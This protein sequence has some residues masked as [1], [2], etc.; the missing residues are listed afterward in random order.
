MRLPGSRARLFS[1]ARQRHTMLGDAKPSRSDRG[2]ADRSAWEQGV[3]IWFWVDLVSE[4]AV[5]LTRDCV[6]ADELAVACGYI[7]S[8]VLRVL[9]SRQVGFPGD[10]RG[11][12]DPRSDRSHRD[13]IRVVAADTRFS[14]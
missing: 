4:R 1:P 12:P 10:V 6:A 2:P 5:V 8:P 13:C 7:A 14:L 3:R 11:E 9:N